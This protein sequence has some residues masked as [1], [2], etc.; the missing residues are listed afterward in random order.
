MQRSSRI[1]II[2]INE[3]GISVCFS[4]F[5]KTNLLPIIQKDSIT[6]ASEEDEDHT[7]DNTEPKTNLGT[8]LFQ[9]IKDKYGKVI[10][11]MYKDRAYYHKKS[12]KSS[13]GDL[14]LNMRDII[15]ILNDYGILDNEVL[16]LNMI[17]KIFS[18]YFIPG[19]N[20]DGIYNFDYE[21]LPYEFI[22][23]LFYCILVKY[24]PVESYV[25]A[26]RS[27]IYNNK[28]NENQNQNNLDLLKKEDKS[29][30][31]STTTTTN[32]LSSPATAAA[33]SGMSATNLGTTAATATATATANGNTNNAKRYE[34]NTSSTE[35]TGSKKGGSSDSQDSNSNIKRPAN[36]SSLKRKQVSSLMV[37]D[38]S[39]KS[40]SN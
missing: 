40:E 16:T 28:N 18:I 8:Y 35:K 7:N 22:R 31:S 37:N 27:K 39:D 19:I 25:K 17:I 38:I 20:Q 30:N 13:K 10:Y 24:C 12:L 15:Y 34:T 33:T 11:D 23:F 9:N 32:D 1:K 6:A 3:E 14:T 29:S 2:S 5:I 36:I 21:V 4:H 26:K